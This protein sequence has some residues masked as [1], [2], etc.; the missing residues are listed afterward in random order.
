MSAAPAAASGP[1]QAGAAAGVGGATVAMRWRPA[2]RVFLRDIGT[3]GLLGLALLVA[4]APAWWV[5]VGRP[6]REAAAIR[7]DIAHLRTRRLG[8]VTPPAAASAA[9]QIERFRKGFPDSAT[10]PA[11][12]AN[13]SRLAG[14]SKVALSSGD[15][16]LNEERALGMLRYEVRY[17]V[18]GAWRDVF[19]FVAAMLNEVPGLALDEVV[20]KRESRNA[21]EVDAQLRLSLFFVDGSALPGYRAAAA[22]GNRGDGVPAR[23]RSGGIDG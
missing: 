20:F 17:P 21:S 3:L 15:Y 22:P 4:A 12:L 7:A 13:L 8:A 11:A 5:L 2:L 10:I 14:A 18:K 19:A 6:A 9:D 16:R 23:P 1:N